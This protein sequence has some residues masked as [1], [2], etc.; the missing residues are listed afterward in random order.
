LSYKEA[1]GELL[2][3]LAATINY[4]DGDAGGARNLAA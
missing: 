3:R 2:R 1:S 4:L